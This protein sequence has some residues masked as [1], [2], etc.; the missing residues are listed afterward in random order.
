MKYDSKTYRYPLNATIHNEHFGP[1]GVGDTIKRV[2]ADVGG[3]IDRERAIGADRELA[4]RWPREAEAQVKLALGEA[5][6]YEVRQL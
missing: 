4:V 6:D 5:A 1:Q 2:V 3:K